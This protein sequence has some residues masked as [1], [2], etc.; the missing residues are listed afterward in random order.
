MS[1][2]ER[3]VFVMSAK[4]AQRRSI[5]DIA[6]QLGIDNAICLRMMIALR[7]RGLVRYWPGGEWGLTTT[8]NAARNRL[9]SLPRCGF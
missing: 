3:V 8:G 7:G 9:T 4:Y 1:T 6:G 2:A 5:D